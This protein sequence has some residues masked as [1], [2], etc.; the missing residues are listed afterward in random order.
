MA[1]ADSGVPAPKLGGAPG[2]LPRPHSNGSIVHAAS[3]SM[4]SLQ[5]YA[6]RRLR[7]GLG[8]RPTLRSPITVALGLE[9]A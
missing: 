4:N 3:A 5:G 2:A 6:A 9:G 8:G 1:A 7:P